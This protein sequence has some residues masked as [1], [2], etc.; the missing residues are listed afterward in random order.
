MFELLPKQL[1][2]PKELLELYKDNKWKDASKLE[3]KGERDH[4][5]LIANLDENEYPDDEKKQ[6]Q[7]W[8]PAKT[9]TGHELMYSSIPGVG[10][11]WYYPETSESSP[12]TDV[13]NMP[14]GTSCHWSCVA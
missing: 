14:K 2:A 13:G 4:K 12:L 1:A 11:T 6:S 7:A 9:D 10:T 5:Q 3:A 8:I